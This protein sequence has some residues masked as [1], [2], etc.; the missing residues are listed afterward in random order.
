MGFISPETPT[1]ELPLLIE[2]EAKSIGKKF[3]AAKA[4]LEAR[5]YVVTPFGADGFAL[6]KGDSALPKGGGRKKA[7]SSA[8]NEDGSVVLTEVAEVEE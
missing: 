8:A 1:S 7:A 3:P 2:F 5:G 6:L 4:N